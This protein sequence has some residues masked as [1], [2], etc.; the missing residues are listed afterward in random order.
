MKKV[1]VLGF[2]TGSL[3]R[4]PYSLLVVLRWQKSFKLKELSNE[5]WFVGGDATRTPIEIKWGLGYIEFFE[6]IKNTFW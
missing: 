2:L 4:D 5:M 3:K 1:E 6:R